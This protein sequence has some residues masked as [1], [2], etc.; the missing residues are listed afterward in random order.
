MASF[1]GGSG[2]GGD[3][4]VAAL[5]SGTSQQDVLTAASID[6]DSPRS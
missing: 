5:P 3:L 2:A 1:G 4:S 6:D